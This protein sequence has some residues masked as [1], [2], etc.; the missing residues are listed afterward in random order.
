M[1]GCF[2]SLQMLQNSDPPRRLEVAPL[3]YPCFDFQPCGSELGVQLEGR[4]AGGSPTVRGVL[5]FL[6]VNAVVWN[7]HH[8]WLLFFVPSA[9]STWSHCLNNQ[10]LTGVFNPPGVRKIQAKGAK[11]SGLILLDLW[12]C[13]PIWKT[14]QGFCIARWKHKIHKKY[15]QRSTFKDQWIDTCYRITSFSYLYMTLLVCCVQLCIPKKS[16]HCWSTPRPRPLPPLR[17]GPM[18]TS[19]AV[20]AS[21]GG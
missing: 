13:R 14:S 20:E 11:A 3:G 7:S 8:F 16:W 9:C 6:N 2:S 4:R 19:L 5:F 12:I 17:H 1:S 21:L 15:I 10:Q 18:V